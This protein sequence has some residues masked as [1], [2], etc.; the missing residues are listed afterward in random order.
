MRTRLTATLG[1]L[2]LLLALAAAP[3]PAAAAG[4]G[5]GPGEGLIVKQSAYGAT[6]TLD[7]L[8]IALQRAGIT[9]VARVK[10]HS[11]AKKA[12]LTLR[13]TEL[14]IFGNP[15]LGTPLMAANQAIGLDLPL[16]AVAW[17]DAGGITHLAYTDPAVLKA[18]YGIADRDPV[19]A[20]MAGALK[21]L[22]DMAVTKGAL[23]A[24]PKAKK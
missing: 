17:E 14:L 20:K 2:T 7:R 15:K 21:K 11:A 9:V 16:R 3:A 24:A 10:H 19:F 18:R 4:P 5:E 22:T 6:K 12:G 1:V 8:G 13:P 23:K